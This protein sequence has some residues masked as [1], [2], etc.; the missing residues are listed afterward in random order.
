MLTQN[1]LV[2]GRGN[3]LVLWDVRL[4]DPVKMVKMGHPDCSQGVKLLSHLDDAIVCSYGSKLR[5]VRFPHFNDKCDWKFVFNKLVRF[6]TISANYN[7]HDQ[8]RHGMGNVIFFWMRP[9]RSEYFFKREGTETTV[10]KIGFKCNKK[11]AKSVH[12][13]ENRVRI[14]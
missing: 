8:R 1:L 10:R 4:P 9:E 13:H 3:N 5:L 11:C 7:H 2:T 6:F 14:K 12:T